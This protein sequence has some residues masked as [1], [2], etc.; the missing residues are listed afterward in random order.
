MIDILR[1]ALPF[2]LWLAAFSTVYGLH[3]FLC[4]TPGGNPIMAKSVLMIAWALLL[5]LQVAI[6]ISFRS[7]RFVFS[8]VWTKKISVTLALAAIIANIWTF[9]P[10]V[11]TT[12]CRALA[13]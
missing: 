2:T 4:A 12:G 11:V 6:L 1:L 5:A 10:I 9:L 8:S 13:L 7:D 3:G